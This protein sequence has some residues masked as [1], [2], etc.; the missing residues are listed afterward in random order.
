MSEISDSFQV[1]E[2]P[3]PPPP[4]PSSESTNS[5]S[6]E[7]LLQTD[8]QRALFKEVNESVTNFEKPDDFEFSLPNLV[9][10]MD[11]CLET[12]SDEQKTEMAKDE[13]NK[14]LLEAQRQAELYIMKTQSKFALFFSA[15]LVQF[16]NE[17]MKDFVPLHV[18]S[19]H[20]R[21]KILL[22]HKDSWEMLKDYSFVVEH[23]RS[24]TDPDLSDVHAIHAMHKNGAEINFLEG[25]NCTRCNNAPAPFMCPS[26]TDPYCSTVCRALHK[27]EHDP[28]CLAKIMNKMSVTVKEAR[29]EYN[30][31][32]SNFEKDQEMFEKRNKGKLVTVRK[33]DAQGKV[34]SETKEIVIPADAAE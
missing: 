21:A 33:I 27:E 14:P 12:L 23:H 6:I 8:E 26:C 18:K 9:R 22:I 10:G 16:Q 13:A 2:T 30:S 4:P 28:H 17:H 11:T 32:A 15:K 20:G 25:V 24:A 5:D 7:S 31:K 1:D 29:E 3:P 19:M 34:I